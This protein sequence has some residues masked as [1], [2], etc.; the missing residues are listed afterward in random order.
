MS[1]RLVARER[2]L[3]FYGRGNY[4]KRI[5]NIEY[6]VKISCGILNRHIYIEIY[7]YVLRVGSYK[8]NLLFYGVCHHCVP[9][10][11]MLLCKQAVKAV[12]TQYP[13]KEKVIFEI[14]K[15]S[16]FRIQARKHSLEF[17]NSFSLC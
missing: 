17:P 7:L 16:S 8:G 4:F 5:Q 9:A 3:V 2:Q 12:G 1:D 15:H 10:I 14:Q 11:R 13:F 6:I